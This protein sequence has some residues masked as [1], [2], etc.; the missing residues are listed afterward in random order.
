MKKFVLLSII[1]GLMLSVVGCGNNS[2]SEVEN[3]I[4][5][6]GSE[7]SDVIST[8]DESSDI[9]IETTAAIKTDSDETDEDDE[10]ESDC[11]EITD[12]RIENDYHWNS[13]EHGAK[14]TFIIKN[15]SDEELTFEYAE[16]IFVKENE[17][18]VPNSA[19]SD[20]SVK[21]KPN[22]STEV[23]GLIDYPDDYVRYEIENYYYSTDSESYIEG[24]FSEKYVV[25]FSENKEN[26]K[27]TEY[28]I[29]HIK[30]SVPNTYKVL[31][32][33]NNMI[34][35]QVTDDDKD[36]LIIK[37]EKIPAIMKVNTGGENCV[38][39]KEDTVEYGSLSLGNVTKSEW[40]KNF[41]FE[42]F[43]AY[44]DREDDERNGRYIVIPINENDAYFTALAMT[45]DKDKLSCVENV[46][47]T[48]NVED[49]TKCLK[50]NGNTK[51]SDT[52]KYYD[53]AVNLTKDDC[54]VDSLGSLKYGN[55]VLNSQYTGLESV[56]SD[57]K[58]IERSCIYLTLQ[59]CLTFFSMGNSWQNY[60]PYIMSDVPKSKEECA[61]YV[62]EF[63]TWMT[64]SW[65]APSCF[66][67]F[68][69]LSCVDI[70]EKDNVY[71]CKISDTTKCAE[72]LN[73][74][75]EMLG[76]II[77]ALEDSGTTTKFNGNQCEIEYNDYNNK[78][79]LS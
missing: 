30:F 8:K 61:D 64:D 12:Y 33:K 18:L 44:F 20:G 53:I 71:I 10:S 55:I 66:E 6:S 28:T 75:E 14:I 73:I 72:E 69:T 78:I 40:L 59:G 47:K 58:N 25:D 39:T 29:N 79:N 26:E 24:H 48:I 49:L 42:C 46:I 52:Q 27:L 43:D 41:D 15:V 32:E 56:F 70:S 68:D 38:L 74:S 35:F 63:L 13:Y 17:I 67:K 4:D 5:N 23:Y 1:T 2:D 22:Q 51:N 3:S 54:T 57:G 45:K 65:L 50:E 37:S 16:L 21:L 62:D 34:T 36:R 9:E 19:Y 7:I 60:M 77:A 11:F 31:N 76:Y